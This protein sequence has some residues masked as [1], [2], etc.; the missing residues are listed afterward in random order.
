MKKYLLF[1]L[2]GFL[3]CFDLFFMPPLLFSRPLN[4]EIPISQYLHTS[5]SHNNRIKSV[6]D[7]VQD[8][9]GFLWLATYR[10]L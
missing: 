8:D 9:T 7:I 5:Y 10:E 6:L 3:A 2:S 4:P 1:S